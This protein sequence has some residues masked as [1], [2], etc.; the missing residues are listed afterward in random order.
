M[1]RVQ[2]QIMTRVS[3]SFEQRYKTHTQ[4]HTPSEKLLPIYN[5]QN[6]DEFVELEA[7]EI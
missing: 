4:Q 1:E 3:K 6:I 7:T 2:P 5:V